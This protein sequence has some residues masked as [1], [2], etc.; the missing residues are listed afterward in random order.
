MQ[1]QFLAKKKLVNL[2]PRMLIS[3][4]FN[5]PIF[6]GEHAHKH[7]WGVC[8][9]AT[10]L[11]GWFQY[12]KERIPDVHYRHFYHIKQF[13]SCLVP[14]ENTLFNFSNMSIKTALQT[15]ISLFKLP[16]D[17]KKKNSKREN[18]TTNTLVC[19]PLA[20]SAVLNASSWVCRRLD[21]NRRMI[22]NWPQVLNVHRIV[23]EAYL[24]LSLIWKFILV[25]ILQS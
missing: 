5:F 17:I 25:S 23:S 24:I 12:D 19:F 15:Q 14:L 13:T 22:N 4:S 10:C 6:S 8:C 11:T 7:F 21:I 1:H 20:A 9:K 18:K 16:S 2:C 3:Q